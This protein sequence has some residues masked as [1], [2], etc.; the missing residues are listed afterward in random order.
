MFYRRVTLFQAIAEHMSGDTFSRARH[1]EDPISAR[2]SSLP[3]HPDRDEIRQQSGQC[4]N[5]Q[6][7]AY[8]YST[9]QTLHWADPLHNQENMWNHMSMPPD[10][11]SEGAEN[12]NGPIPAVV[13]LHGG[14]VPPE[15][16]GGPDAW[17]TSDGLR[18]GNGFYTKGEEPAGNFHTYRYPNSG[19][20]PR[21]GS[22]TTPWAP[23]A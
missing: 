8:K 1:P 18:T 7:L 22:T 15:L 5:Y 12:Y 2:W 13:H 9:D 14:E 21:S 23:P 20:A 3:G 4:G 6:V 19:R 11:G 10:P 17:V 16:D